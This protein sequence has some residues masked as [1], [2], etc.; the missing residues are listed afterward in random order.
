MIYVGD[1]LRVFR[2]SFREFVCEK[3]G[4]D[5][6]GDLKDKYAVPGVWATIRIPALIII[7]ACGILL[8]TTQESLSH[9][10]TMLLTSVGAILPVLLDITRKVTKA[11]S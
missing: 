6:I 7:S 11:G 5:E 1:G 8:L 2:A 10:V 9:Q 4:S 3:K